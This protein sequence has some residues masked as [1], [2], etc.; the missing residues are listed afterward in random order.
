MIKGLKDTFK[1]AL[2]KGLVTMQNFTAD[3]MVKRTLELPADRQSIY[4]KRTIKRLR[5]A[6][7]SI[8]KDK[9]LADVICIV[10][11]K[12]KCSPEEKLELLAT[13]LKLKTP[14]CTTKK[15]RKKTR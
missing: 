12:I 4:I 3:L 11:P 5:G 10:T 14:Y 1:K 2:N 9:Y 13:A 8:E 7:P 15:S 6:K